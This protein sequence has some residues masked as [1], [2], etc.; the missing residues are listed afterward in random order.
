MSRTMETAVREDPDHVG[1]TA[2]VAV[3]PLLRVGRPDLAPVVAPEGGEG[4]ELE[5]KKQT[6]DDGLTRVLPGRNST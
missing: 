3:E 1:P 6:Q 4:Q 2:E 5:R